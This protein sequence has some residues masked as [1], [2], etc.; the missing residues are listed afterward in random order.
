MAMPILSEMG[1]E[2]LWQVADFAEGD[3]GRNPLSEAPRNRAAGRDDGQTYRRRID[4][5]DLCGPQ[6]DG[7]AGT[8]VLFAPFLRHTLEI[9]TNRPT[10]TTLLARPAD[11]PP[12]ASL[13]PELS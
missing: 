10:T 7:V 12:V 1:A 3:E 8:R 6:L 4:D 2:T 5:T 9:A 13:S 11:L